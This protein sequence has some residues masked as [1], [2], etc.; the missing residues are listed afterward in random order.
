MTQKER[1]RLDPEARKTDILDVALKLARKIGYKSVTATELAK[2]CDC[3][4][5]LIFYHFKSM[6]I[7]KD[8]IM[9]EA[10]RLEDP[11]V[12]MQGLSD[13]N[14]IAVAAPD[15]LKQKAIKSL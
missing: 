10:V 11:I 14:P 4:H 15:H 8:A 2:A 13:K 1:T 3:G 9:E 6:M 12:L 5:P 7:L